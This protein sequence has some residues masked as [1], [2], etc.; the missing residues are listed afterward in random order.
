MTIEMVQLMHN[1]KGHRSHLVLDGK[2]V[3]VLTYG[4]DYYSI[5]GISGVTAKTE[6]LFV[7]GRLVEYMAEDGQ[8]SI[9]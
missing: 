3:L 2:E 1:T 9:F 5:F 6:Y 4:G 7:N 8:A